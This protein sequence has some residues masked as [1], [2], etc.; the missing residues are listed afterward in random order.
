[1]TLSV[2]KAA[3]AATSTMVRCLMPH[4]LFKPRIGVD[5]G[6]TKIEAIVLEGSGHIR[7]RERVP[8]PADSYEATIAA[9]SDL[10][11]H[12]GKPFRIRPDL[13]VG[14]GTPG[15]VSLQTGL[16]KNS[17][18]ILLNN[19]PLA[20]DLSAHHGSPVRIA[21]DAD[22]FTLSEA[23]D[24]AG[25]AAPLT[26]G[27]ILGTGVGGGICHR[28]QLLQGANAIS[29]EWGHNTLPLPALL[30]DAG[31]LISPVPARPCY[32]GRRDC[33]E[34]WLSGPAFEKTWAESGNP[35]LSASLIVA[36]ATAGD[37]EA[38]RHL[39]LYSNMLALGL[40][41]VINMLDPMVIVLGGGMSNIEGLYSLVMHY[42]P[43]YVFSDQVNTRVLQAR[44]GDSSG[45]RGAAWLWALDEIYASD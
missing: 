32:C 38:T 16:M 22:C 3:L 35:P 26:F 8:T 37:S 1:M 6:G 4:D 15:A 29:G 42:L 20:Q 12:L 2:Y 40:S 9:V 5:L 41:N 23:T 19:R 28:G 43:R 13:P 18:S 7:A 14:I 24:G 33:V 34:T 21:N 25:Q 11:R 31:E 10:V 36:Q 39:R 30:P 27:V 17:N 45:V 44:H